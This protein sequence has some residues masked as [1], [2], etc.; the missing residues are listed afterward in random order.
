MSEFKTL[1]AYYSRTGTTRHSARQIASALHADLEE[2]REATSR[3]GAFGYLRS[4]RDVITGRH[5]E[6]ATPREDPAAYDLVVTGTPV[7]M[8]HASSPV[9]TYVADLGTRCRRVAFFST[10]KS[11]PRLV[12]AELARACGQ[13]PAATLAVKAGRLRK[14]KELPDVGHFAAVLRTRFRLARAEDRPRVIP[15][16][17]G[18][19]P[20]AR[21]AS[22]RTYLR[23][24]AAH[25]Q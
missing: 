25:R 2:I 23:L 19:R 11:H 10:Y 21:R 6:I 3:A 4:A 16:E 7:W 15:I 9:Q 14:G 1:V 8:G 20:V 24:P 22:R 12:F 5:P 18:L 17:S 13:A